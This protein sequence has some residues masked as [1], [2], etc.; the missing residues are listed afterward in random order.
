MWHRYRPNATAGGEVTLLAMTNERE[1]AYHQELKAALGTALRFDWEVAEMRH[2]YHDLRDNY[3]AFVVGRSLGARAMQAIGT[4]SCYFRTS[5]DR[6]LCDGE[7]DCPRRQIDPS[8]RMSPRSAISSGRGVGASQTRQSMHSALRPAVELPASGLPGGVP[9]DVQTR[10]LALWKGA[11]VPAERECASA[12]HLAESGPWCA[13]RHTRNGEKRIVK[14]RDRTLPIL[15]LAVRGERSGDQRPAQAIRD[16]SRILRKL[17]SAVSGTARE[18]KVP[19]TSDPFEVK[20][21]DGTTTLAVLQE[22]IWLESSHN[23]L[24]S[25]HSGLTY[26]L[27]WG[28]NWRLRRAAAAKWTSK[29]ATELLSWAEA[30]WSIGAIADLQFLCAADG[31]LFLFDPIDFQ[32]HK[33]PNEPFHGLEPGLSMA[34][35]VKI[36]TQGSSWGIHHDNAE[37]KSYLMRR[38]RT[39]LLSLAIS[40]S[41]LALGRGDVLERMQCEHAV[42]DLECLYLEAPPIAYEVLK[43]PLATYDAA[44]EA[45]RTAGL[46][47]AALLDATT[48]ATKGAAGGASIKRRDAAVCSPCASRSKPSLNGRRITTSGEWS[49][50]ALAED[51]FAYEAELQCQQQLARGHVHPVDHSGHDCEARLAKCRQ[52]DGCSHTLSTSVIRRVSSQL[53]GDRQLVSKYQGPSYA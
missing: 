46:R 49:C 15:K 34:R 24:F 40:A 14:S 13:P 26:G 29:V 42:C 16:E 53:S 52:S 43:A 5:C 4:A 33:M 23:L 37:R 35:P 18:G 9:S 2:I 36:V 3:L 41:V 44:L 10:L 31:S 11:L 28:H 7:C 21:P 32:E 25:R 6:L 20:L 47:A 17:M 27:M 45:A 38:Q 39:E 48:G 19:W 1:G 12:S 30:L 51:G 50:K 8:K 22:G